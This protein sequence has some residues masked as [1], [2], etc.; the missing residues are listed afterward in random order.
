MR[1][2]CD[3]GG[4]ADVVAGLMKALGSRTAVLCGYDWGGGIALAMGAS[5]KHKALVEKIACMHP[6]F[7]KENVQVPPTD[8]ADYVPRRSSDS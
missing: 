5:G 4:A 3:A 8:G 6:A 7:A 1:Q 2:A